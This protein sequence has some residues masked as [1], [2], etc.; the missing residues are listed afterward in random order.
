VAWRQINAANCTLFGAMPSLTNKALRRQ[1]VP[2]FQTLFLEARPL[3]CYPMLADST[4]SIPPC[5]RDFPS[6]MNMHIPQRDGRV[7]RS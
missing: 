7:S 5:H 1:Q 6:V 4:R 3:R 2:G